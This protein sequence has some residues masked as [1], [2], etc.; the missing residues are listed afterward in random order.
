MLNKWW[1]QLLESQSEAIGLITK[2][3]MSSDSSTK[4]TKE[5]NYFFS[6]CCFP[7]II[8]WNKTDRLSCNNSWAQVS[9]VL[10]TVAILLGDLVLTVYWRRLHRSQVSIPYS[11]EFPKDRGETLS[12]SIRPDFETSFIQHNLTITQNL[13]TFCSCTMN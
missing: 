3:D 6:L 4:C 7:S 5:I 10:K 11:S 12:H 2:W 13:M 8:V 1:V 9:V